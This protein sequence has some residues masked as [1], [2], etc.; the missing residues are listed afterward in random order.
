MITLLRIFAFVLPLGLDTFAIAVSLGMRGVHPLRPAVVFALFETAMPLIGL[1]I[2]GVVGRWLETPAAYLGGLILVTIGLHTIREAV[3]NGVERQGAAFTSFHTIFSAG[4]GISMDEIAVGFA[5]GALRLP[6]LPVLGAIAVQTLIVT[7][8]GI[9]V[10]RVVS[11]ISGMQTSRL[12][13]IAAGGVFI[14]LGSYLVLE[15]MFSAS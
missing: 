12:A 9:L 15:R 5:L 1:T 2:G 11:R 4:F 8:S 10:G 14:L 6:I 13:R 3:Q 7:V